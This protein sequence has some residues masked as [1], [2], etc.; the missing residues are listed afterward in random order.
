MTLFALY[1]YFYLLL[2]HLDIINN[3]NEKPMLQY[4][5]STPLFLTN[6]LISW[7]FWYLYRMFATW[8]AMQKRASIR[9]SLFQ[10][11]P[12]L[13]ITK[14]TCLVIWIMFN[15]IL[16]GPLSCDPAT[17]KIKTPKFIHVFSTLTYKNKKQMILHCTC[18]FTCYY[19]SSLS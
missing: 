8:L 12:N 3:Q 5:V 4:A 10:F 13:Q 18:L 16:T 19:T 6:M 14:N 11:P 17:L 9:L 15:S 1:M 7:T 2:H